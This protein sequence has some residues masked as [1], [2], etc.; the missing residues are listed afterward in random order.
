M[1]DNPIYSAHGLVP[2]EFKVLILPNRVEEKTKGGIIRPETVQSQMQVAVS[3]GRIAAVSPFAFTYFD[4]DCRTYAEVIE[5][6]PDTPK[7]GDMVLYGR[8]CGSEIYGDDGNMYRIVN[9]KD[10]VAGI[11]EKIAANEHEYA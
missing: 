8:Y 3:K 5:R 6:W 11:N 9:D 4:P 10:I 2:Y 7:V 1:N